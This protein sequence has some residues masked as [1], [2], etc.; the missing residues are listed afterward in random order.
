MG[1]PG[2]GRSERLIPYTVFTDPQL[3]GVGMTERQAKANG[4]RCEVATIPFAQIARA[5]WS[6]WRWSTRRS[7]R[8]SSPS[9]WR[10]TA[11]LSPE[12]RRGI[13]PVWASRRADPAFQLGPALSAE[14]RVARSGTADRALDGE[15]SRSLLR[16]LPVVTET[17]AQMPPR[18][19]PGAVGGTDPRNVTASFLPRLRRASCPSPWRSL[20]PELCARCLRTPAR[21]GTARPPL[22]RCR[23][24]PDVHHHRLGVR[25]D[26][27]RRAFALAPNRH[28]SRIRQAALRA[29][30]RP[31]QLLLEGPL[32]RDGA[33]VTRDP[34]QGQRY[35]GP[36]LRGV[37]AGH[38]PGCA[39]GARRRAR[40]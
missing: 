13:H 32:R 3:A 28:E 25:G 8:G 36:H 39:A 18:P 26:A 7:R 31:P 9:S 10:S 34:G 4:V 12:R 23:I 15:V 14:S 30:V 38:R 33:A 27:H 16:S 6:T 35:Q 1:R 21:W 5:P 37:R 22:A 29:G 11:T 20:V 2:R 40:R 24:A 17:T 19:R